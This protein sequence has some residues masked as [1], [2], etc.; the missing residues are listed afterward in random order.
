MRAKGLPGVEQ[1]ELTAEQ[2]ISRCASASTERYDYH[3]IDCPACRVKNGSEEN[4]YQDKLAKQEE[5][6]AKERSNSIRQDYD[7]RRN[8]TPEQARLD[9]TYADFKTRMKEG[10]DR[11][12][13]EM[14]ESAEQQYRAQ[15]SS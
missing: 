2:N 3:E 1:T 11:E 10:K 15:G 9:G 8:V 13:L 12:A 5:F 14:R 7:H 6:R 4:E